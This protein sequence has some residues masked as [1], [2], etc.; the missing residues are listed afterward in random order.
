MVSE[1]VSSGW[2]LHMLDCCTT[3]VS[4]S[5][6]LNSVEHAL[7][8]CP[9]KSTPTTNLA[10]TKK[11]QESIGLSGAGWLRVV[12]ASISRCIHDDILYGR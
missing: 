10:M 7:T 1:L 8:H 6:N 4:Q 12:Y 2:L 11:L 3:I 9:A 5:W